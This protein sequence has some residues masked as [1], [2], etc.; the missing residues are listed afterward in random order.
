MWNNYG[1]K[2]DKIL[3]TVN[4]TKF[5]RS[6]LCRKPGDISI[7]PLRAGECAVAIPLTSLRLG[8]NFLFGLWSQPG[9]FDWKHSFHKSVKYKDKRLIKSII[10][11]NLQFI[12]NEILQLENPAKDILLR[13][14]G[15][16][17][18]PSFEPTLIKCIQPFS[19]RFSMS[20]R[21]RRCT[22]YRLQF[23]SK[24]SC[25]TFLTNQRLHFIA[26]NY[27]KYLTSGYK[28]PA[29]KPVDVF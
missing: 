18:R 24:G 10:L 13:H 5:T 1:L 12:G 28:F 3:C 19:M 22:G 26:F 25:R 15:R 11:I 20:N 16:K 4:N 21:V 29:N 9:V 7:R 27:G 2:R 8:I 17:C 14:S 6:L 23:A